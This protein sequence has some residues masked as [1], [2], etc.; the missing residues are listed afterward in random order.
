MWLIFDVGQDMNAVAVTLI[1]LLAASEVAAQ[2]ITSQ[3]VAVIRH[4][5]AKEA[6]ARVLVV[7]SESAERV[8][9]EPGRHEWKD[10]LRTSA[11]RHDTHVREAVEDFITKDDAG[12][13]WHALS[14]PGMRL[15]VVPASSL[16][17]VFSASD[18]WDVFRDRYGSSS[19]HTMS[20]VGFSKDRRTA[21]Y[22]TYVQHDWTF[23]FGQLEESRPIKPV[24]SR[25]S[26]TSSIRGPILHLR[27]TRLHL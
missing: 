10:Q 23:G 15:T 20:C 21:I 3:E 5:F 17:Q 6:K 25:M 27:I 7:L 2:A 8:G 11:A 1:A 19:L 12:L 9:R 22:F 16:R 4:R 14:V 13:S 24:L 26:R 18:G